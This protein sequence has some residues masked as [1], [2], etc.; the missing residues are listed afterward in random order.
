MSFFCV[1]LAIPKT[2]PKRRKIYPGFSNAEKLAILES[3]DRAT[4]KGKRNYSM[5]LLA[6]NTGLRAIDI[7]NLK[8]TDI[9]WRNCE[10]KIIQS[11]TGTP[12]C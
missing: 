9:D 1:G 8:L 4:V 11:K 5:M 10:I 6:A 2:I 12:L 3:A 7:A